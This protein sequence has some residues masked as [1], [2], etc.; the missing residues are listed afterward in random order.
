MISVEYRHPYKPTTFCQ[1]AISSL[2]AKPKTNLFLNIVR[3]G[4]LKGVLSWWNWKSES[5]RIEFDG[6][7]VKIQKI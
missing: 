3:D 7:I 2:K 6:N 4:N 1:K 5:K